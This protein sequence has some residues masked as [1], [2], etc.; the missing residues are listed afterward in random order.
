MSEFEQRLAIREAEANDAEDAY[1]S[2]R[3]ELDTKE[4]RRV[5]SHAFGLAQPC[6][7]SFFVASLLWQT[8]ISFAVSADLHIWMFQI[9]KKNEWKRRRN[10]FWWLVKSFF[11]HWWDHLGAQDGDLTYSRYGG[12][13]RGFRNWEVWKV[14][15]TGPVITVKDG[16][17]G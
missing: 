14:G 1:F 8:M 13:W 10:W 7:F 16:D 15:V 9:A 4:A 12:A 17:N 11:V 3:P 2:A 6:S 5:F